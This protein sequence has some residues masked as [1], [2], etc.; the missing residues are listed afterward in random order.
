VIQICLPALRGD[1]LA[2]W[3]RVF[4]CLVKRTLY[5]WEPRSLAA[6][7]VPSAVVAFETDARWLVLRYQKAGSWAQPSAM[8]LLP[9]AAPVSRRTELRWATVVRAGLSLAMSLRQ[10][11]SLQA[12]CFLAALAKEDAVAYS[13]V[14]AK[15]PGL[16]GLLRPELAVE[17]DVAG[18]KAPLQGQEMLQPA[19]D[20]GGLLPLSRLILS[21]HGSRFRRSPLG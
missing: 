6:A 15:P 7:D 14:L 2:A 1:F 21:S 18:L 19:A 5:V 12:D 9:G 4:A 13:A 11:G 16:A 3:L 20:P 10:Q 8:A 17:P